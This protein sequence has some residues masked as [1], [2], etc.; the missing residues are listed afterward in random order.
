MARILRNSWSVL[1]SRYGDIYHIGICMT[2]SYEL[3]RLNCLPTYLPNFNFLSQISASSLVRSL[4]LFIHLP[5]TRTPHWI[6]LNIQARSLECLGRGI[7]RG[8][9]VVK[10]LVIGIV[11]S[12]PGPSVVSLIRTF[13]VYDIELNLNKGGLRKLYTPSSYQKSY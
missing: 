13:E 4:I 12:V 6:L 9:N 11:S 1:W 7:S 2:S 3:K 5:S 8:A 10:V